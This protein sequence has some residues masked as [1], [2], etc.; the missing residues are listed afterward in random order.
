MDKC[1]LLILTVHFGAGHISVS[2]AIEEHL[3]SIDPTYRVCIIDMNELLFSRKSK[4]MYRNFDRI[5]KTD[6]HVYNF[7]YYHRRPWSYLKHKE[8]FFAKFLSKIHELLQE[9][10]PACVL[11]TFPSSTEIMSLYKEAYNSKIL[12][13]TCIT[14]VVD[15]SEW[16]HPNNDLYF[17]AHESIAARLIDKDISPEKLMA[18]GI[19]V[20][21]KFYKEYSKEALKVEFGYD[22]RDRVI[23]IMGGAHGLIP[24]KASFYR[25]LDRIEH[26]KTVI[27]SG[28]NAKLKEKLESL[29]LRNIK[30][31]E[32]TDRMPEYMHMVDILIGKAGGI[33]VFEAIVSL[34]PS[35]VYKP[36]LGQEMENCKFIKNEGLGLIT[37]DIK[38]LKKAVISLLYYDNRN[39]IIDNIKK[40]KENVNTEIIARKIL[41]TTRN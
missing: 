7:Y 35:I 29:Q 31:I 2:N 3:K 38:E 5:I 41:E 15:N 1:D 19:P 25:W 33:T 34:L 21:K 32:H 12:L 16:I 13:Y 10:Q 17:V 24:E 6:S 36:E 23:L 27:I 40:V 14:D 20:G 22:A 8:V 39:K 37:E 28:K 30:V 18:T 9:L 11:S 4:I 26:V